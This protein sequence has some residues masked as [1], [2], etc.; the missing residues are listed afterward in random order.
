MI[1]KTV[2][3]LLMSLSLVSVF[4]SNMHLYDYDDKDYVMVDKIAR[5]SG[6][7]GPSSSTPVTSSELA[8]VLDRVDPSLLD[9]YY[10]HEYDR[11]KE[12]FSAL[13]DT[14][15]SEYELFF[16]PQVYLTRDQETIK[17]KDYFIP[18]ENRE[19][20]GYG[21]ASFSFGSNLFLE[22]SLEAINN[23]VIKGREGIPYTS[24][25]FIASNR[26]Q[27]GEWN[28]VSTD[29]PIQLFGEVPSLARGAIGNDFFS[30]VI[31]RSHHRMGSGYSGNMVVGDNWRF[32]EIAKFTASSNPFTYTMD[33]THFDSQDNNGQI[34]KS[35][36]SGDQVLRLIHRFDFNVLNRVRIIANLGFLMYTDNISDMRL[37]TPLFLVHN[38]YNFR[39]GEVITPGDEA[40]NIMSAEIEWMII[41]SLKTTMQLVV[42]QWKMFWE[43]NDVPDAFGL[44]FNISYLDAIKA[45]DIDYYLEG[46]Y[47]APNLYLNTKNDSDGN[48][49]C[50]YDFALGY[51]RRD[52]GGDIEWSG[53]KFGPNALG[54][55]FG[56]NVDLYD[57]NLSVDSLISYYVHGE[58]SYEHPYIKKKIYSWQ[59]IPEHRFDIKSEAMWD[60]ND[61]I[62]LQ[63]AI[64]FGFY[65]N[66]H[67]KRGDFIFMPQAMIGMKWSVI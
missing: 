3:I 19:P 31:G 17:P 53:H 23:S 51:F 37:F 34:G 28:V 46:V 64:N 38:W 41:P 60:I 10:K 8:I 5:F 11:L 55:I 43:E 1:R 20:A 4:A 67:H 29:N 12:K 50:N 49:N 62:Q 6:V 39:E 21:S 61:N 2:I 30:I 15:S 18:F 33:F 16:A 59:G 22:A 14:F 52:T 66:F 35:R 65:W 24:F 48:K 9:G 56:T 45:G 40:N 26:A 47:T 63:A 44:M 13:N 42:D 57:Y 54:I 7:I 36:F 25:D 27:D 32:Q 58:I